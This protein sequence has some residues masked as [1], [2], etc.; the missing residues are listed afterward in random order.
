M[1]VKLLW[2]SD[3]PGWPL[4]SGRM[5][6]GVWTCPKVRV[7]ASVGI[8][9]RSPRRPVPPALA[10][11]PFLGA[12]HTHQSGEYR[13]VVH[14]G[15]YY[16]KS[17][18]IKTAH[19]ADLQEGTMYAQGLAAIALCEAYAMTQDETLRQPAQQAIDFICYAQH[20][21]GGWRDYPGRRAIP[22]CSVGK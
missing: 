20:S 1:K 18:I 6:A 4:T 16:L 14:N 11:L 10:L 12:G 21:G 8:R 13:D 2:H 19:G 22:P 5:V 15:L 9:E 3:S 17:R 7:A